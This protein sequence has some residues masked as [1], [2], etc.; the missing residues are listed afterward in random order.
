MIRA[1]AV[2]AGTGVRVRATGAVAAEAVTDAAALV[3]A[4]AQQR[5]LRLR[6]FRVT[7]GL[8]GAGAAT[9]MA[10]PAA[11]ARAAAVVTMMPR[12]AA[13]AET[14]TSPDAAVAALVRARAAAR[15]V[16]KPFP[17]RLHHHPRP[18]ATYGGT[19]RGLIQ[20]PGVAAAAIMTLPDA[21]V[22]PVVRKPLL[23]RRHPLHLRRL[24]AKHAGIHRAVMLEAD[25]A[26]A[27]IPVAVDA[28]A[29]SRPPA[30]K[31]RLSLQPLRGSFHSAAIP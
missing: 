16:P 24:H 18:L 29:A 31:T 12:A 6:I 14:V 2:M 4:R 30:T 27:A 11:P 19:R 23:L 3:Q 25:V 8:V 1:P 21:A 9:T 28:V 13:V 15:S 5:L 10:L 26:G 20:A 7:H 22:V 17:L